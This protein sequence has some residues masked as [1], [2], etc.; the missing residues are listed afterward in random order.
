[1]AKHQPT[2]KLRVPTFGRRSERSRT[3]FR[4][5]P[6]G[7][8]A[9]RLLH[10]GTAVTLVERWLVTSVTSVTTFARN[11]IHAIHILWQLN[12]AR[13]SCTPISDHIAVQHLHCALQLNQPYNRTTLTLTSRTTPDPVWLAMLTPPFQRRLPPRS[14]SLPCSLQARSSKVKGGLQK[15]GY[16]D[17]RSATTKSGPHE[18]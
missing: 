14:P 16:A 13:S 7:T 9:E 17:P 10:S 2:P 6:F 1:M 5:S 15:R 11:R 12:S 8:V 3:P 18:S 4:R